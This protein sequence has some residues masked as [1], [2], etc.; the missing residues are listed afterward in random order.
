MTL[1]LLEAIFMGF[2]QGVAEFLPISSSGHL[3]LLQ[4]FF[5]MEEVDN[6]F[7]ILL[8]FAT[9]IA[10]CVVY[11][12]DI[13]EM[14]VEFFKGVGSLFGG[15]GSRESRPPE[16]RRLV[17]MVIVGTLPLFVVLPLEGLVEG[18]GNYPA[19]VSVMLLVTGC[20]LFFSDRVGDGRK[21]ARTAT[22]KDALLVGIAQ[23][24][25]TIPGISRS[26]STISAGL[27][28][29]F[30]RKFAV[31]YSFLLSLPAV[32]GATLLKVVRAFGDQGIDTS[33]LPMYIAGMVVAGVVGYFSIQLVR[34]LANKGK[35]GN[36]AYYCWI[37][38]IVSLIAGFIVL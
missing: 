34:L 17:M 16:A 13:A 23:G 15:H 22:V 31:R 28:L 14:I 27:L 32:L 35:F 30:N 4:H 6:L 11:R 19:A 37:V 18:L 29:G 10:V 2:V 25:A 7:N 36:F 24:V 12:K 9:L 21:T 38:G 8:H 3:T 20:I 33:L 1:S 5:K 26:G